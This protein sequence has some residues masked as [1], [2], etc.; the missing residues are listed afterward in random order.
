MTIFVSADSSRSCAALAAKAVKSVDML[1]AED[2]AQCSI[3]VIVPELD[4]L[5]QVST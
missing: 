3:G 1:M 2:S 5:L 4:Q